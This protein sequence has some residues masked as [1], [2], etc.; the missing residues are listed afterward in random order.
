MGQPARVKSIDALQA[1]SAALVCFHDD[2]CSALDDL[3]MELRR[4]LQWISSGLSRVL[5]AG[6]SPCKRWNDR[7]PA[8]IGKREDVPADS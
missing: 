6:A 5:E 2:A 1:M 8:A 7:S 3:D 4:V